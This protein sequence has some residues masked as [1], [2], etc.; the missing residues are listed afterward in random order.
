[1]PGR[2]GGTLLNHKIAIIF[3]RI[4][5]SGCLSRDCLSL[6]AQFH[7]AHRQQTMCWSH[8]L[9]HGL[10]NKHTASGIS[11]KHCGTGQRKV[12]GLGGWLR[13]LTPEGWCVW[14]RSP[15]W[16]RR[17]LRGHCRTPLREASPI[18][19]KQLPPSGRHHISRSPGE[20]LLPSHKVTRPATAPTG[21]S[22]QG[23]PCDLSA[24]REQFS[25]PRPLD[26]AVPPVSLAGVTP[27]TTFRQGPLL[28]QPDLL[29]A[30]HGEAPQHTWANALPRGRPDVLGPSFAVEAALPW[31]MQN[32][33]MLS[34]GMLRAK[35]AEL[36]PDSVRHH[37]VVS[38][39]PSGWEQTWLWAKVLVITKVGE[40]VFMPPP[41][42]RNLFLRQGNVFHLRRLRQL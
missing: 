39:Q 31:D 28:S 9:S 41:Q 33:T 16:K 34:S 29:A 35:G 19:W 17:C 40:W 2:V 22:E 4:Q 7:R 21:S 5:Y 15:A 42:W 25:S 13:A 37:S 27:T 32:G 14:P 11:F 10:W 38:S 36:P 23:L 12:Y 24:C 18:S 6:P 3:E 8:R 1:M 26:A 30:A 20:P